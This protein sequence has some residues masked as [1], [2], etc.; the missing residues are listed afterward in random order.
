MASPHASE[1]RNELIPEI[2]PSGTVSEDGRSASTSVDARGKILAGRE[3]LVVTGGMP[4]ANASAAAL[5][6]EV[7]GVELGSPESR[8]GASP[9]QG[10]E[11]RSP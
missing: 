5:P 7:G 11:G 8:H 1:L 10:P 2:R 3:L 4:G 6:L 9:M